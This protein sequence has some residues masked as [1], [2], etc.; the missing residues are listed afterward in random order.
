MSLD[1]EQS[2][3]RVR[4]AFDGYTETLRRFVAASLIK[5]RNPIPVDELTDRLLATL[6]NPPVVDRR[7]RD[8]PDPAR[9]LLAA[10]GLTRRP[11]WKV[12]HL[13]T[14]LAAV[15]H[16]DGFGPVQAALEA[17][18][19]YP[20]RPDAAPPLDSFDACLGQAGALEAEVFA[21]PAVAERAKDEPFGLPNV[22]EKG[23]GKVEAV[24]TAD[25]LEWPLRLAAVTQLVAETP[26]RRTQGGALF[27]RDLTRFQAADL[28]AAPPADHLTAVPDAGVLALAWAAAVGH[29]HDRDGE[30]HAPPPAE[31]PG[32][33]LDALAELVSGLPAV[34]TWDPL[35]GYQL[36]DTGLSPFPSAAVGSLLLLAAATGWVRPAAVADWLWANHPS[37]QGV[38]PRDAQKERGKPW[39]DALLLGVLYPLRLVEVTDRDG[40]VVRLTDVGRHLFAAGPRPPEPPAFPQTL[41]VQPTG[42]ILAY[43]QGLT[44]SLIGRL[45]RFARWKAFGP[46]CTLELTAEQTY[47]GLESGMTLA[48]IVQ[49]LNQHGTRPV[50]AAAADLLQRWADKR[51]R[52]SVYPSAT[53]VEFQSAADLDAA[54]ARG[55]VAVR[56]TDR[57]GLC[58][59]GGEPDFK[60]LRLI[61]NRDFDAKPVRC[62][63]VADDGVTLTV[64][65]GQSDLL[66]EAEIGRLAEPVHGEP[67]ANGRQFRLTPTSLRLAV[68]GGWKR[69]DLDTWFT[70]RTGG[71]LSAAGRLFV[72]AAGLPPSL[73][74]KR[75]VLQLPTAE[76]TDGLVQWPSTRAL[77]EDRLG[78]TAVAVDEANLPRLVELLAELGVRVEVG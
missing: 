27:K 3:A 14:L 22:G 71:P 69:D 28:L 60:L 1:P 45:T 12:G 55:V 35:A 6:A 72:H 63:S 51:E 61:G 67:P 77:V 47:R 73:A 33:L 5:P 64:D 31:P 66:L 52:I 53:L 25:G 21:H 32:S 74:S 54:V 44:P 2:S 9:K 13:L 38:L 76:A 40:P 11:R 41:L 56:V 37:W 57:I 30:L 7:L 18:L 75:L 20:V 19:L 42:E 8:L 46:A 10:L 50:P 34:E 59:D 16:A 43:R 4:V 48:G 26:V 29:L 62:V 49:T 39:A 68:Q 36:S 24:R 23:N 78:P 65:A 70:A 58:P 17:G 15:G